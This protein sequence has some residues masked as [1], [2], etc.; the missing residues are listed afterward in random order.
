LGWL[1]PPAPN[2]TINVSDVVAARTPAEHARLVEC[3]A[4]DVWSSWAPHHAQVRRWFDASAGGGPLA[5]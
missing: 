4:R 1:E 5:D 2:G 3:W